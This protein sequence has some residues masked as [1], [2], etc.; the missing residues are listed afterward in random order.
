MNISHANVDSREIS[1]FEALA[2]RWWDATGEFRPL[3]A[4]N[5]LRLDYIDKCAGLEGKRVLD[6]GCGGGLLTEA[7]AQRGAEVTGIDMAEAPL[8]VA[9]LHL[10]ESGLK[11]AY[12][13][14]TAE[15][16]AAEMPARFHA[17]T[18]MEMLE[19][20]PEPG[21]VVRACA[22]LACPGGHVFFSTFNRNLKSFLFA[23]VAGEYVLRLIPRGTH[24]YARFIR[25][26]ELDRWARDGG[27]VLRNSTGLHYQ[28]LTRRYRLG[29]DVDV[30]YFMHFTRQD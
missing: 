12:R 6:I 20:V 4:I 30:N 3:H 26:S 11:V 25:P 18:C 7:M 16:L 8:A 1:R 17:V 29:G 22:T 28:P 24:G 5:P 19:H 10:K 15:A 14:I 23:I 13:R 27:L 9:R 2:S 21:S